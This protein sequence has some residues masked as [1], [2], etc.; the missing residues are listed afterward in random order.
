[1]AI[2]D[3]SL[4]PKILNSAEREF[5]EKGFMNASLK[6]IA[7]NAGVTT[8][9][10][11]KRYKGK[12]ELFVKVVEPAVNIFNE[13]I[14]V[15]AKTNLKRKNYNNLDIT[16]EDSLDTVQLCFK[17]LYDKKDVVRILLTKSAGTS[18][19]NFVHDF[20]EENFYKSYKFME[21]L[22]KKGVLKLRIS[23]MEYHILI[24]SYW[25]TILEV[26][27]HDFTLDEALSFAEKINAFYAWDKLIEM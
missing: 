10:I 9:A 18:Y 19:S 21:S 7:L 26:F 5:L 15:A 27:V 16:L 8:G 2:R 17:M 13:I 22:E 6:E 4:G 25:T 12:E 1:M 14:N 23:Y 3:T 20:I 11:Y 24:T